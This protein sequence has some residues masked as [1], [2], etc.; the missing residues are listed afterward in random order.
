MTLLH[1]ILAL[2]IHN[3]SHLAVLLHIAVCLLDLLPVSHGAHGVLQPAALL[4]PQPGPITPH[5]HP[6]YI[7]ALSLYNYFDISPPPRSGCSG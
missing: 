7:L 6:D 1:Y 3:Y 5:L 2:S 4:P